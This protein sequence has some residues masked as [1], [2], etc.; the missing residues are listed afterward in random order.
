MS[1]NGTMFLNEGQQ[2]YFIGPNVA[3]ADKAST[4][5]VGNI[6]LG[7][8]DPSGNLKL[9]ANTYGQ[10]SESSY[11]PG[12]LDKNTGLPYD[13]GNIMF[14]RVWSINRTDVLAMIEDYSDGTIDLPIAKDILEWPASGSSFFNGIFDNQWCAPFYDNN[15][16][17]IYDPYAGDYPKMDGFDNDIIPDQM[18][19]AV[20]NDLRPNSNVSSTGVSTEIHLTMFAFN[21]PDNPAINNS[22]FT[23]HKLINRGSEDLIN[24]R[25]SLFIDNDLGCHTDDYIG[26]NPENQLFYAYNQDAMDGDVG[27]NCNGGIDPF[28]TVV[29]VQ[30][31]R[32]LNKEMRSFAM[33]NNASVGGPLP[34][35]ADPN[36]ASEYYNYMNG[37]WRDGS[38]MTF[39]GT[40]YN[41]QSTD[42]VHYIFPGNPNVEDE[43]SMLSSDLQSGDR[44]SLASL[45]IDEYVPGSV[46]QVDAVHTLNRAPGLTHVENVNFAI[47]QSITIQDFYDA[48]FQMGCTQSNL[49]ETE[50]CVYPGDVNDNEIVE[51]MDWMLHGI[52]YA[53]AQEIFESPR[54]FISTKWDEFSADPRSS[55]FAN[56]VNWIHA[57]CNGNGIVDDLA[58]Q[59]AILNNFGRTTRH[60]ITHEEPTVPFPNEGRVEID[61]PELVDVD[62]TTPIFG[63]VDI[64]D[65]KEL[66][67]ISFVLEYDT[68][69]FEPLFPPVFNNVSGLN[70]IGGDGFSLVVEE[71]VV[72][73]VKGN[74]WQDNIDIAVSGDSF[75]MRAKEGVTN[76]QTNIKITKIL[77]ADYQENFY[78]LDDV[79]MNI[80]LEGETVSTENLSL[81]DLVVY[82]NPT[83]GIV[84]LRTNENINRYTLTSLNGKLLQNGNIFN[85]QIKITQETG[86]YVLELLDENGVFAYRKIF[87]E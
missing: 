6:W 22:V 73:V 77:I 11:Q 78:T 14:D 30:S 19:F 69:I 81:Q 4:I 61:F 25:V 84:H 50:F 47:E 58:D 68:D 37:L 23:R 60:Y 28:L 65:M 24:F 52:A 12:P 10:P 49:C 63:G 74:T 59:T 67:S 87:V 38:Q 34:Q 13:D 1:S 76:N 80:A 86:M 39:G 9:S 85:Q 2:G 51:R 18:L 33:F 55:D 48:D 43:W 26:C 16:D 35:T 72:L 31:T 27:V 70:G 7:G 8:L 3:G 45:S 36:N 41:L 53:K 21:C 66:H 20:F 42:T 62:A 57:D 29:P 54:S 64:I 32:F 44:R 56:D 83:S 71:G 15:L 75:V 40:G 79:V 82:P 17:G 46:V 5:F